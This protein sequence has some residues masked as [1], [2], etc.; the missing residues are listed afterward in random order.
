M[1]R[2]G[3]LARILRVSGGNAMRGLLSSDA[4]SNGVEV[5]LGKQTFLPHPC[6]PDSL[7]Q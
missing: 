3:G 5:E 6:N 4:T 1:A 2:G 7:S